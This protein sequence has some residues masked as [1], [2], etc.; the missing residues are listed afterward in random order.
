MEAKDHYSFRPLPL[1]IGTPA[2][3]SED[4]VGLSEMPSDSEGERSKV[5]TTLPSQY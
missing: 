4:D 1:R 3:V 5:K 2:F